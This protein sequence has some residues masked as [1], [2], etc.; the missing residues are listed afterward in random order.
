MTLR[1]WHLPVI[2][3]VLVVGGFVA[4]GYAASGRSTRVETVAG[5]TVDHTITVIKKVPV[6]HIRTVRTKTA[7]EQTKRQPPVPT[8]GASDK[9]FA[10]QELQIRDDGMGDIGGIAR[11]TNTGTAART[12]GLT[13]TFF[14]GG[15]TVGS[16][17]GPVVGVAPGQTV[18]VQLVSLD[19]MIQ[20]AF[21]YTFQ[22][23]FE[24]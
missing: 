8:T 19:P 20:G 17:S 12:A 10:V 3:L 1:A 21:T 14:Q 6:T 22:V 9:D 11:V 5:P 13:F 15:H 18:T 23:D 4:G 24:T 7:V 2:A 16:A